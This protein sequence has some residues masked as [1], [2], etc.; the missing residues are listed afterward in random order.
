MPKKN[1]SYEQ[2]QDL[3]ASHLID[4]EK[5]LEDYELNIKDKWKVF[6]RKIKQNDQFL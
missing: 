1:I 2:L 5:V 4:I 3:R 6:K